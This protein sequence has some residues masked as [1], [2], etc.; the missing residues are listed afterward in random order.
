MVDKGFHL[1]L[2]NT[3]CSFAYSKLTDM[4][5]CERHTVHKVGPLLQNWWPLLTVLLSSR[6]EKFPGQFVL[7]LA[8]NRT[9]V[10][11]I[12]RSGPGLSVSA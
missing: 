5:D 1:L 6:T 11:P 4:L 12:D 9:H 8:Q 3:Y 7:V 2:A 10:V